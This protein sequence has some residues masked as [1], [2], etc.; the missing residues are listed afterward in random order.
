LIEYPFGHSE[1]P[2]DIDW[3]TVNLATDE[4][5]FVT[6]TILIAVGSDTAQ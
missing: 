4:S 1:E 3:R 5:K 6:D 2:D